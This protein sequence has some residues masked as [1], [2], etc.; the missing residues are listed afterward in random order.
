M[1]VQGVPGDLEQS[2]QVAVVEVSQQLLRRL[3]QVFPLLSSLLCGR[4]GSCRLSTGRDAPGAAATATGTHPG[5]GRA[6][7]LLLS[8]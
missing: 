4:H 8:I 3:L 7:A 5:W 6:G 1:G 2:V